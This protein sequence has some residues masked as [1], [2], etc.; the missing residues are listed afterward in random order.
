MQA[1]AAAKGRCAAP[2]TAM[3]EAGRA[4]AAR[5]RRAASAL[6]R[7]L[8]WAAALH[9]VRLAAGAR[10][11]AALEGR[12]LPEGLPQL[13]GGSSDDGSGVS[14][15]LFVGKKRPRGG[16]SPIA[17]RPGLSWRSPDRKGPRKLLF[18]EVYDGKLDGE[19]DLDSEEE[20]LMV[21]DEDDDAFRL[22]EELMAIERALAMSQRYAHMET[23]RM[24]P[25]ANGSA[26][27]AMP[28]SQADLQAELEEVEI[29]VFDRLARGD[30]AGA[31][32]VAAEADRIKAL[33][34]RTRKAS[35]DRRQQPLL[36][37]NTM[38]HLWELVESVASEV[39]TTEE[40]LLRPLLLQELQHPKII[41]AGA[42]MWKEEPDDEELHRLKEL[43]RND[44]IRMGL[45]QG[46][47]G[48]AGRS[49]WHWNENEM[50]R[51]R[52][53]IAVGMALR[54]IIKKIVA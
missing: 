8:A 51:V 25:W 22:D 32:R 6:G 7:L 38:D 36:G 43:V 10:L 20:E 27:D 11:D 48:L 15:P 23:G 2:A 47:E 28:R 13:P 5:G 54:V 26:F 29:E 14:L 33:I 52:L 12:V 21:M 1:L 18:D 50:E 34:D 44:T 3:G 39:L 45:N 40:S 42:V 53:R 19:L 31:S 17:E 35:T 49:V 9:L 41:P 30:E 37:E 4:S 16:K 46:M 24:P